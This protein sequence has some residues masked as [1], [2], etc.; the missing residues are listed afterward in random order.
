MESEERCSTELLLRSIV[1]QEGVFYKTQSRDDP[2]LEYNEKIEILR[3]LFET[4]PDIFLQRYHQFVSPCK[5]L[6]NDNY[7]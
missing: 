7:I 6:R 2:E 4:K 1:E 3:N 5:S